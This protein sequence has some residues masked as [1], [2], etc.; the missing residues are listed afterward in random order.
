MGEHGQPCTGRPMAGDL[1]DA[2]F[3][4]AIHF[5]K[6][7]AWPNAARQ[8][9][10]WWS[11]MTIAIRVGLSRWLCAGDPRIDALRNIAQQL[12]PTHRFTAPEAMTTSA[13][14]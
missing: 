11:P 12:E 4:S 8:F 13:L 9:W 3:D 5:M 1:A 7:G 6:G 10:Q 14:P 2:D